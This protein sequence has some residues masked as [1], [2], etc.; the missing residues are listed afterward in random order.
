MDGSTTEA[1]LGWIRAA[2]HREQDTNWARFRRVPSTYTWRIVDYVASLEVATR[3]RLFESFA[4]NG[5]HLIDP[6][7]DVSLHASRSGD[8]DY[9]AF[10]EGVLRASGPVYYDA[11]MLRMILG[12]LRSSRPSPELAGT[13]PEVI[14]RA[15]AITPVTAANIRRALKPLLAERFGAAPR[16]EPGGEWYYVGGRSAGREF[17]LWT[18]FG[19]RSDQLR[20]EIRYE[21]ERTGIHARRLTYEGLLGFGFGHWDFVT[22][23]NLEASLTLL[24]EFVEEMVGLPERL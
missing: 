20:Y 24:C 9:A 2:I 17:T 7:R 14:R 1:A 8:P 6:T 23:D 22:A 11:R 10:R 3:D 13:P 16:K 4:R 18:D 5:L 21:D 15:E 12:D 19:G